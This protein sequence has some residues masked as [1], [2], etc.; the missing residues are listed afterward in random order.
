MRTFV[1]RLQGATMAIFVSH[2]SQDFAAYS[3]LCAALDG[4]GVSRWDPETMTPGLPLADQL[5]AAID[6]CGGCIFIA[7]S[8]S[9]AS[10]WCMAEMGAFWGSGKP[11]IIFSVEDVQASTVLP[12]FAH[13]LRT[14]DARRVVTAA[15]AACEK[16]TTTRTVA[17][18]EGRRLFEYKGY[19][20]VDL[21]PRTNSPSL[22]PKLFARA[23]KLFL[24]DNTYDRLAA[25]DLVYLRED[26][27]NHLGDVLSADAVPMY[28]RLLSKYELR[29]FQRDFSAET[30]RLLRNTI[31]IVNDLGDT[32]SGVYFEVLLHNVRNPLR[33]IIAARNSGEVSGR[34][35]GDPSTRFVVQYVRNQGRQLIDAM[36]SGSKIAY[37]KQFNRSKKVKATTTPLYDDQYGL[38][39]ILCFNVDIDAVGTLDDHGKAEFLA[40]YIKTQ[41]ETPAFELDAAPE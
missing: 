31:R 13:L 25:M 24:S 14:N 28:E 18:I 4:A 41:G 2:A 20:P 40:K 33:S 35:I 37:P 10:S 16:P 8:N 34:R 6:A 30:E 1:S 27:R 23:L 38:I 11:V 12:Q 15:K 39:G 32:L 9:V 19:Y 26:N 7:T 17:K 29:E 3:S 5:R 36:T 22:N 21:A